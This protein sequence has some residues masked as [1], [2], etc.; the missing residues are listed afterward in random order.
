MIDAL[1][2]KHSMKLRYNTD[3]FVNNNNDNEKRLLS[4]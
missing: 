1:R 3:I 2:I 4:L